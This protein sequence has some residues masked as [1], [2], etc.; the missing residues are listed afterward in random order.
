MSIPTSAMASTAEGL[1][2]EVGSEPPGQTVTLS[3]AMWRSQPAAICERP[4]LCTHRNH[5]VVVEG[6]GAVDLAQG[7]EAFTGEPFSER[8]PAGTM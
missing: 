8:A 1:I 5:P 6:R 7:P 4:A 3:P 2:T